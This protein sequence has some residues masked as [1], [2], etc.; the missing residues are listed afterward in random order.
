MKIDVIEQLKVDEG[1]REKPYIDTL[2]NLTF[3]Y[4]FTWLSQHEAETVLRMRVAY[5]I[6]QLGKISGFQQLSPN[7]QRVL[8]NMAFNL[9]LNGLMMFRRMWQAIFRHDYD[10]AAKEMLDSKW[11]YQVGTRA[12]RLA[13]IMRTG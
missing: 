5:I 7:R 13:E 10:E 2:G 4:G 12:E 6:T 9:G 8:I 1:F 11:A 3:G